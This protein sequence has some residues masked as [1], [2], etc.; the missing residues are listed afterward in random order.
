MLESNLLL[1]V[2]GSLKRERR[3]QRERQKSIRF[4]TQNNNSARAAQFSVTAQTLVPN[5]MFSGE[6]E[7]KPTTFFFFSWT[8]IQSFKIQPQKKLPTSDNER[9]GISASHIFKSDVFVAVAVVVAYK[10]P[11]FTRAHVFKSLF[12]DF[13]SPSRLGFGPHDLNSREIHPHFY[14]LSEL[15]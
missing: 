4:N 2:E 9:D 12:F 14:I 11:I 13:S 8:L 5:F 6:H 10:L 7:H 3:I 15:E 1:L